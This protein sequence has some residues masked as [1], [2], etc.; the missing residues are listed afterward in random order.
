MFFGNFWHKHSRV[1]DDG[2]LIEVRT[3]PLD[4]V[5]ADALPELERT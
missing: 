4:V 2:Y 1:T 3:G 5:L